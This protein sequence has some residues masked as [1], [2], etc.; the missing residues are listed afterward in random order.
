MEARSLPSGSATCT[1]ADSVARFTV[2][3][4]TPGTLRSARSTRPEQLAQVMPPMDRSTSWVA[5]APGV[6]EGKAAVVVFM[7][8]TV[9]PYAMTRSSAWQKKFVSICHCHAVKVHDV[10]LSPP[11]LLQPL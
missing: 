6:E 8:A 11:P 7:P 9:N 4:C 2:A 3:S 1:R 5:P 10:N